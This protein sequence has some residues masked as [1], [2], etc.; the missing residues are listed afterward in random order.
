MYQDI[1]VTPNRKYRFTGWV[2]I[3][4]TLRNGSFGVRSTNDATPLAEVKYGSSVGTPF[5]CL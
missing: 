4:A 2:K 1:A 5:G 3:P